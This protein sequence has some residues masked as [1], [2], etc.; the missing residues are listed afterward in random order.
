MEDTVQ[1]VHGSESLERRLGRLEV[2]EGRYRLDLD[3]HD[4]SLS[5]SAELVRLALAGIAVVGFIVTRLPDQRL[6]LVFD[7]PLLRALIAGS[8]VALAATAGFA[9][10]HRFYA[11]GAAFHHLQVIKLLLLND[12]KDDQELERELKQRTA[13]FLTCHR[14]LTLASVC[15]VAGAG[16]LGSAFIRLLFA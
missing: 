6:H 8:L 5:F 3:L 2:P 7:D 13:L 12:P 4:R 9:L 15:L 16:L 14:F 1:A 11:G 10:L